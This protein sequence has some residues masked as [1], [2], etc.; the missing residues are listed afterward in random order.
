M[1][2]KQ[3]NSIIGLGILLLAI[4][5][6]VA[7]LFYILKSI[8]SGFFAIFQNSKKRQYQA[9]YGSYESNNSRSDRPRSHSQER[10]SINN[11]ELKALYRKVIHQ[12]HPDLTQSEGDKKFRSSWTARINQA[13]HEGDIETLRSFELKE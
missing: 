4:T 11:P 1:R 5:G 8:V 3:D 2:K 12:Y 10:R 13:Y 7:L 9:G 6:V